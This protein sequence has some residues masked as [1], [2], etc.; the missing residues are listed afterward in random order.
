VTA[1]TTSYASALPKNGRTCSCGDRASVAL[2]LADDR[3]RGR[4]KEPGPKQKISSASNSELSVRRDGGDLLSP[5]QRARPA[6][7]QEKTYDIHLSAQAPS[8]SPQCTIKPSRRHGVARDS[9][10]APNI[11]GVFAMSGN[12]KFMGDRDAGYIDQSGF[13][14]VRIM[15]A[16][17]PA[18]RHRNA[19]SHLLRYGGIFLASHTSGT[20]YVLFSSQAPFNGRRMV[21]KPG[22]FGFLIAISPFIAGMLSLQSWTGGRFAV[23][24]LSRYSTDRRRRCQSYAHK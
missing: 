11:A 10:R 4:F 9:R 17:G 7:N 1:R 21:G 14:D 8:T 20:R 6:E 22:G 18:A 16:V 5:R 2:A 15:L 19:P 23:G 3:K 13:S 24:F 12:F